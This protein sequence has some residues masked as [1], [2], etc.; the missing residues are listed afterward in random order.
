VKFF[1]KIYYHLELTPL[2]VIL[3]GESAVQWHRTK[4]VV[5]CR[6]TM[7]LCRTTCH[8]T[9]VC[10]R[11]LPYD[12]AF[13]SYNMLYDMSYNAS[14][15]KCI[16]QRQITTAHRT[17]FGHCTISSYEPSYSYDSLWPF[18]PSYD[19]ILHSY[20]SLCSCVWIVR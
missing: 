11:T 8:T 13:V 9:C 20:D 6:T 18:R 3:C 5:L 12:N 4:F 7:H 15:K 17:N 1:E 10:R 2:G 19:C 14:Y 16:V